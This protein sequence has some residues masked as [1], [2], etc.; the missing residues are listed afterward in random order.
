MQKWSGATSNFLPSP[1][2]SDLYHVLLVSFLLCGWSM[3]WLRF[4]GETIQFHDSSI[5][6]PQV[7]IFISFKSSTFS[8]IQVSRLVLFL[9][10]FLVCFLN[11]ALI[12]S[13]TVPYLYNLSC[14]AFLPLLLL[15]PCGNFFYCVYAWAALVV[16]MRMTVMV[17]MVLLLLVGHYGEHTWS[18]SKRTFIKGLQN[19]QIGVAVQPYLSLLKPQGREKDFYFRHRENGVRKTS[20]FLVVTQLEEVG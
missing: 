2:F 18:D 12:Y 14:P 5:N 4:W 15:P 1:Q 19:N 20:H 8:Q 17:V 9:C 13:L 6:T 11:N 16:G 7:I 3:S 10:F